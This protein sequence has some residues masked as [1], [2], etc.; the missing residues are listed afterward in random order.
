MEKRKENEKKLIDNLLSWYDQNGRSLPWRT[1]RSPYGTWISEIML[2]QTRVDT[3]VGYYNRFM[4][5]IPD[6]ESLA[7]VDEEKLLKLWQGLGYYSRAKNLKKAAQVLMEEYRGLIPSDAVQLVKLPG[8]GPYTAGA[9]ASMAF[10]K[11]EPAIDGNV[12]RIIARLNAYCNEVDS[13]EGKKKLST[14]ASKWI[15]EDRPGDLNQAW[16]D[17]G[18]MICLPNGSPRCSDCPLAFFCK[19]YEK[20]LIDQIPRK[21][22]KKKRK[23]EYKTVLVIRH[24][25]QFALVKQKQKGLLSGLWAFPSLEG[26][27]SKEEAMDWLKEYEME[28]VSID[29]IESSKHLFS[30]IEWQMIAFEVEVDGMNE[31]YWAWASKEEIQ[32]KYAVPTAYRKY[33]SYL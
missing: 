13:T 17:L 27:Q 16:M 2:Q 8:I 14:Y 30:H 9:I 10:Q 4:K 5:E 25:D 23:I 12:L 1:D 15:S 19:A 32:K 7:K 29:P 3:V 6:V 21:K 31:R 20:N 24:G 33:L 26:H 28:I 22:K 18:A 11:Q